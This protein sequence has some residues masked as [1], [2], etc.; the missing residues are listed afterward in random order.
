[1]NSCYLDVHPDQLWEMATR[2]VP[3]GI[4]DE[5][6]VN[7]VPL[8][9]IDEDHVIVHANIV[10]HDDSTVSSCPEYLGPNRADVF[11]VYPELD[12]EDTFIDEETGETYHV[13]RLMNHAW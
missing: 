6:I 5:I 13:P 8:K 3:V 12:G 11:A 7:A 4:C 2:P 10:S 1:M 9:Q